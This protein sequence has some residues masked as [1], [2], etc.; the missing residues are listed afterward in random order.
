MQVSIKTFVTKDHY[1]HRHYNDEKNDSKY[2]KN[3]LST[4]FKNIVADI[5]IFKVNF[6]YILV[7]TPLKSSELQKN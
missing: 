7:A 5:N 2:S 1:D 3:H 4:F 6:K